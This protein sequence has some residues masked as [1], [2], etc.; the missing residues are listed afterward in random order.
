MAGIE[1]YLQDLDEQDVQEESELQVIRN[2]I[3][4]EICAKFESYDRRV[5][6][7]NWNWEFKKVFGGTSYSSQA[8][9]DFSIAVKKY[10]NTPE[11]R[12]VGHAISVLIN[13]SKDENFEII[14]EHLRIPHSNLGEFNRKKI[15][16]Y[17][18]V[19]DATGFV[20]EQG[21]LVVKG[22][23]GHAVASNMKGGIIII[24][25]NAGL[26]TGL[27]MQGGELHVNG[28]IEGLSTSLIRAGSKLYNKGELVWPK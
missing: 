6:H 5:H 14:T 21:N 27:C 28:E 15:I 10:E 12:A 20:M 4:E 3:V 2:P 16:V 18:D 26:L 8:V 7:T 24:E 11:F 23:A 22:N 9:R 25:G 1:N 17:G 19:G 13:N